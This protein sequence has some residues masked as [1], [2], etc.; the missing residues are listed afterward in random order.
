MQQCI[1]NLGRD[2]LR[3]YGYTS[4]T[5]RYPN[6]I[7]TEFT[8]IHRIPSQNSEKHEY[9]QRETH[10]RFHSGARDTCIHR[11]HASQPT[12][13]RRGWLHLLDGVTVRTGSVAFG[14]E[15]AIMIALSRCLLVALTLP[16]AL[17]RFL[18]LILTLAECPDQLTVQSAQQDIGYEPITL[19]AALVRDMRQLWSGSKPT[20]CRILA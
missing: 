7:F 17:T 3:G 4:Q 11:G 8:A 14:T 15:R 1:T 20:S 16:L 6:I 10:A 2:P 5:W 13:P 18:T 9:M 12:L 19:V